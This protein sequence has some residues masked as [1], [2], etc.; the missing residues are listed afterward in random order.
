MVQLK[1]TCVV[2]IAGDRFSGKSDLEARGLNACSRG[3][4]A[5]FLTWETRKGT[6]QQGGSTLVSESVQRAWFTAKREALAPWHWCRDNWA[7]TLWDCS[8]GVGI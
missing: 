8:I 3:A 4:G 1:G 2:L 6:G 7:G 5:S